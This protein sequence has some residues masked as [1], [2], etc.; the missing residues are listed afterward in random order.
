MRGRGGVE[1]KEDGTRGWIVDIDLFVAPEAILGA[2]LLLWPQPIILFRSGIHHE[3]GR[4]VKMVT[5][6]I[7]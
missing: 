5:G 4:Q 2:L 3:R 7:S 6:K 1:T